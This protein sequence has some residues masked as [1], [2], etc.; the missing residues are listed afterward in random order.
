MTNTTIERCPECGADGL[1]RVSIPTAYWLRCHKCTWASEPRYFIQ[2]AAYRS[3]PATSGIGIVREGTQG[4]EGG[5]TPAT[6]NRL[7]HYWIDT[8]GKEPQCRFCGVL[9]HIDLSNDG[10]FCV[11]AD[12][13]PA[14]PPPKHQSDSDDGHSG[15][16]AVG[17][18]AGLPVKIVDLLSA[19]VAQWKTYHANLLAS[20][21]S[22]QADM[23]EEL[24]AAEARVEALEKALRSALDDMNYGRYSH[25]TNIL[26][27]AL[28][29]T[30]EKPD[31]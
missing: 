27:A 11:Y 15:A 21:K 12:P 24:T 1:M 29:Q 26:D 16:Q 9:R 31:V 18:S 19:E 4:P 6:L 7:R 5:S 2:D 23:E 3:T 20:G 28:P 22:I 13:M 10:A 17:G 25:A 30:K 8:G 14:T